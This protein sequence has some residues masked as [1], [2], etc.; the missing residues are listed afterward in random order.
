MYFPIQILKMVVVIENPR[1]KQIFVD[2]STN[3]YIPSDVPV[4][5]ILAK[6]NKTFILQNNTENSIFYFK[7]LKVTSNES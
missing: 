7:V 1:R 4:F 6:Y 2:L 5:N 3:K